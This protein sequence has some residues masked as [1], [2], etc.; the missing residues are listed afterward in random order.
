MRVCKLTE[1]GSA[2]RW[3]LLMDHVRALNLTLIP[4][5]SLPEQQ[6]HT[7]SLPEEQ[8][9]HTSSQHIV[10]VDSVN[11]N[12]E[13]ANTPFTKVTET[14]HTST[15]TAHSGS[16]NVGI[17]AQKGPAAAAAASSIRCVW[18]YVYRLFASDDRVSILL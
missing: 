6:R 8:Q 11:A 16:S 17:F 1:V 3:I 5:Q 2:R 10:T 15:H 4:H 12:A 13:Q 7:S 18:L 14:K 9:S